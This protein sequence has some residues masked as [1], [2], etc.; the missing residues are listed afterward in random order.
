MTTRKTIKSQAIKVLVF[1]FA[2]DKMWLS[3]T[4]ITYGISEIQYSKTWS[5]CTCG[6][7]SKDK[8]Q[9]IL[10]DQTTSSKSSNIYMIIH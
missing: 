4:L 3:D 10:C 7:M 8:Y 9:R 1:V 5:M 2:K 6:Q